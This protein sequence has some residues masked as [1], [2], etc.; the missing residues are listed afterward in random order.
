LYCTSALCYQHKI[1]FTTLQCQ[2]LSFFYQFRFCSDD[3]FYFNPLL[4]YEKFEVSK[5]VIRNRKRA[6]VQYNIC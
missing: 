6:L 3:V 5:G 4:C 1:D 2:F